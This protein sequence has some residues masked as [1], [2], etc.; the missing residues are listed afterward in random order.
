MNQRYKGILIASDLDGTFLDHTGAVVPSN[1]D[2]IRAFTA[3]GGLFTFATGRHHDHLPEAVPGVEN[4]INVPAIVAN[5][6]YLYDFRS[7]RVLAEVFMDTE[8]SRE[9]LL[10]ARANYPRVGFRVST[11]LG[12]LTDGRT[13]YMKRFIE[14]SAAHRSYVVEVAPVEKWTQRLWH[15]FVF[16]GKS[17]E[18]DALARDLK[19][20]FGAEA[21]EYNKSSATM[22]EMQ[23]KGCTKG[24]MLRVL[25][26][27]YARLMG[28]P[29]RTYGIGDYE[30]DLALLNA[31][32]IA[33]CP[34]NAIDVV[35]RV[36]NLT[37]C[38]NDAGVIA[39]LIERL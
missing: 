10:F 19:E 23:K 12:Y 5:G 36:C 4:L 38:S 25:Q 7:N 22:L 15:K 31:A 3:G 9:V 2:A 35:K 20:T 16:R 37:L 13:D 32:D 30:N 24:A 6:S 34:A 33:V 29:I 18:L 28:Q 27:S 8:A 21:F 14:Y 1:I 39:D 26:E 17:E 11:P